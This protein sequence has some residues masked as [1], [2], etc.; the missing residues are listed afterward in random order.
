[1]QC[2]SPTRIT[3]R[4]K[5]TG[6]W[7]EFE[8]PCG[9]CAACRIAKKREWT[10]RL[11]HEGM[12][13]D[14]KCFITLTYEDGSLPPDNGL[15]KRD[16]QLFFKRLRRAIDGKKIRYFA[17]GEYG[18][19]FG[20]PHY[21]AI[22][23]GLSPR[24]SSVVASCW[25]YGFIRCDSVSIYR[26]QYV[27]G[28]VQKKLTKEYA[29]AEFN[30]R[31]SPFQLQS[32]SIGLRYFRDNEDKLSRDMSCK[33]WT[34]ETFGIP[35]YYQRKLDDDGKLDH[36]FLVD[37]SLSNRVATLRRHGYEV[38][39]SREDD[40]E[41]ISRLWNFATRD[42]ISFTQEHIPESRRVSDKALRQ[43]INMSLERRKQNGKS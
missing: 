37:K 1:M 22:V 2:T 42:D 16:L 28:Y 30:G 4:L 15:H 40:E 5:S 31:Q 14:E 26:I 29:E 24:D 41:Y 34:G 17:C 33:T 7:K 6:E 38:I 43:K 11:I 8:V 20:R 19:K 12:Y 18:D 39:P 10:V 23:F 9:H 25:P 21:H 35:K 27:A 36:V 32:Q 3:V 13:W